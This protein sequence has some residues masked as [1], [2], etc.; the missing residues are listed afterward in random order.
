MT[1]TS[2]TLI[3]MSERGLLPKKLLVESRHGT[4]P[5]ALGVLAIL[6]A[7]SQPLDFH[8]LVLVCEC[9]LCL[10]CGCFVSFFYICIWVMGW[11]FVCSFV[12]FLV[13]VFYCLLTTAVSPVFFA[14]KMYKYD[15][16]VCVCWFG[17]LL[18]SCSM[19]IE[20][21]FLKCVFSCF[22]PPLPRPYHSFLQ[23]VTFFIPSRP[24]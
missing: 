3:G 13:A 6:I 8:A 19:I 12:L 21:S 7:V 17:P 4:H 9:L 24:A 1:V 16:Y 14:S 2:Q 23:K 22:A 10:V 20:V 11:S 18:F 5:Y 15:M